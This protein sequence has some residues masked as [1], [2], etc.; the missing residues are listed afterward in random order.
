RPPHPRADGRI[1]RARPGSVL[2][3]QPTALDIVI[4]AYRSRALVEACLES[5]RQHPARAGA[6]V[7]VVDNASHDGT[8]ELIGRAFP[9]VRLIESGSNLGFAAANNIAIRETSSPYVLALNPDTRMTPG[10]L[11]RLLALMDEHPEI[12]ICGCRLEREDGTFDHASRR[13]FPTV[14]GALGHFLGVGRRPWAP[15]VLAQYRAPDV[16]AGPVDAVNGAF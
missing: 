8:A 4:V 1:G 2:G 10:A 14:T 13:S 11:D 16:E 7:T 6:T 15:K 5:V 9:E 12:G 3:L